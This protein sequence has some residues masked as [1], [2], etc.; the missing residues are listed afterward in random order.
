ML[1]YR[2]LAEGVELHAEIPMDIA[3]EKQPRKFL[4]RVVLN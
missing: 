2:I 4:L 3:F 1:V